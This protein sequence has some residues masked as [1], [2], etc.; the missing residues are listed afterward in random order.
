[1]YRVPGVRTYAFTLLAP[2]CEIWFIFGFVFACVA[3]AFACCFV[4]F[5]GYDVAESAAAVGVVVPFARFVCV[6]F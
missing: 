4:M 2:K 3:A 1:M 5:L 6:R